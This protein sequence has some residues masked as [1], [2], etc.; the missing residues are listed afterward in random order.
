MLYTAFTVYTVDTVYTA[1][2]LFKLFILFKLL[3]RGSMYAYIYIDYIYIRAHNLF[4]CGC[5]AV[6]INKI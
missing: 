6:T 1:L 4:N 5:R 3:Y 2:T